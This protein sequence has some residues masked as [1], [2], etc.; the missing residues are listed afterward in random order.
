M[1]LRHRIL[2]SWVVLMALLISAGVA[3][4]VSQR[5][6]AIAQVDDRLETLQP[7]AL[8]VVRESPQTSGGNPVI[9]DSRL[10]AGLYGLW[11]GYQT[12]SGQLI[13]LGSPPERPTLVPVLAP[14]G[15]YTTPTTVSAAAP[16]QGELRV[17][18]FE[19]GPKE[20]VLLGAPLT[21][22]NAA[23]AR[24]L[25]TLLVAF[26]V[27]VAF[28]SAVIWWTLRL[29]VAPIRRVAEVARHVKAGDTTQRVESFPHGTEAQELGEAFNTLVDA[30]LASEE[31]LRRFVADAS[32]EL[33]T[34]LA[35]LAGYTSL[36]ASGGLSDELAVAD[37]MGRMRHEAGR[38]QLLVDDL[39][40]LTQFD[41]RPELNLAP[42]DLVPLVAGLV[43]DMRVVQPDRVITFEGPTS[44]TCIAD[45][46]RIT[47][48][49]AAFTSNAM[50]H[51]ASHVPVDVQISSD[52]SWARIAVS[53][54]GLGIAAD[55]LSHV[56]ER[57]YRV[58]PGRTRAAGGSGLGLAIA[59]AIASAHG[60]RIGAE[61]TVGV[62]STFWLELP[63]IG[64]SQAEATLDYAGGTDS[65]ISPTEP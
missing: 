20:F 11:V 8:K 4:Y 57:F 48:V 7:T 31:R 18:A 51:T 64:G 46:M 10:N 65:V 16:A 43:S 37:A 30:N 59:T 55:D 21:D 33:R 6:F 1:S 15:T 27:L 14:G 39:M 29:G 62:G 50:R 22:V 34:P 54:R 52:G 17:L 60:G 26:A 3:V 63:M 9:D 53:D 13:T 42:V 32:H 35:T 24:L 36:Y 45:S 61:S 56:F 19:R 12:S 47:Q 44:L 23:L 28:S 25:R 2:L 40:L 49:V 41:Q 58:D 5:S 38:M